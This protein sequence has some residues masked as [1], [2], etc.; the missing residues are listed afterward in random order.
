MFTFSSVLVPPQWR[1]CGALRNRK[2]NLLLYLDLSPALLF[3]EGCRIRG[4]SQKESPRPPWVW[5][6]DLGRNI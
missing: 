3:E 2:K 4:G 6:A 5:A 1:F